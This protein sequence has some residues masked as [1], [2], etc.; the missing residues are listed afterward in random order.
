LASGV[1]NDGS[2]TFPEAAV[3][4]VFGGSRAIISERTDNEASRAAKRLTVDSRSSG[5][6][7]HDDLSMEFEVREELLLASVVQPA[8]GSELKFD[9][10]DCQML[11]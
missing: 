3:Q 5:N 2:R 11:C 6:T 4:T 10:H 8:K 7:A 9:D 1:R